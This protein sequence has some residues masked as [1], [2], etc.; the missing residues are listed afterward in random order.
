MHRKTKLTDVK[1]EDI[2]APLG[3]SL[4]KSLLEEEL[5]IINKVTRHRDQMLLKQ[6]R[7]KNPA[8]A[9]L[10]GAWTAIKVETRTMVE[11]PKFTSWKKKHHSNLIKTYV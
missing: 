5:D 1:I 7:I 8:S 4:Q 11:S 9:R 10:E 2:Y 3:P 6:N